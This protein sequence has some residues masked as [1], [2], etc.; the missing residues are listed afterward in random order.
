MAKE[1]QVVLVPDYLSVRE[2]SDLIEAS[3]IDVMKTL[4]ANGIMASINQQVDF[5]TAAIVLEELGYEAR[6]ETEAA[7]EEAEA[8]RVEEMTKKWE[9]IY[10][11]E[12]SEDLKP[13]SPVVTILGHVDHG[14]TTLL[15]NIRHT[16]VAE[17]EAG[18]ITQAIGAYRAKHN[19]RYI[20]FLDT[21][22]HEAFTAMRARGAQGADI[23]ILVVAAD[24]GVMPT[25]R[26]ALNHA[27]AAN[28]PIVVAITKVDKQNA[29]PERVKQQLSELELVPDDWDGD[30][31]MVPVA[32]LQ[33]EGIDDLLEAVLLVADDNDFVA[34][35]KGTPKGI[36]IEAQVD[37]FR[38]T[39]ATLL[40]L[41]GTL[42][43]GDSIIAGTS[44]GRIKAMYDEFGNNIKE[45][46]PSV[47]VSVLGL[48]EPPQPG[49]RFERLKN[50]KEARAIADERKLEKESV[51]SQPAPALTLE[52]IF[53]QFQAGQ[54]KSLNLVIKVDVLGSLQP[55][56]DSLNDM[57]GKNEEGITINILSAEVGN[58]TESDIMLASASDAIV[59]GFN[60]DVGSAAKNQASV[61]GVDVRQY[62]VIYKL[63]EDIEM[64]LLGMLEPKY[65]ERVIGVAEVRQL[66]KIGRGVI[67]GCYIKEGE[68]RR[69]AK[70]RVVRG[71]EVILQE[72]RVGSLK[73]FEEDVREVRTGFE[74]GINIDGF[75]DFQEGDNIEF[76]VVEKVT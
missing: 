5:D 52:D 68:A 14:K 64:A 6:S 37:K 13:R 62:K 26:E 46:G 8:R 3:P 27:R 18:G 4:I 34:N 32:A 50:D 43:V 58:V 73:R 70:V 67:A 21:P 29:S 36:V 23:A 74:C 9:Q 15:D 76:F 63:L 38:G 1:L 66:F 41:N 75:N 65:E 7:Q 51:A 12:K 47:P 31:L 11:G 49:D 45:A 19:D 53:S 71:R 60:V 42:K 25:T 61:H 10:A 59:I 55:I 35:P 54:A 28:V 56:V 2:L 16:H 39:L 30:T 48:D 24:D 72:A 40:V 44:H 69:N 17:G 33:G 57:S 20:T 22:G